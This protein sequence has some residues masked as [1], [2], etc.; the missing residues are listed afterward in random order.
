MTLRITCCHT[1]GQ[2]C[3][4]TREALCRH[5]LPGTHVLFTEIPAGDPHAYGHALAA[6]WKLALERGHALAVVEPDIVVR[7]D[8]IVSFLTHEAGYVAYPYP[9]TTDVGP[10]LGCNR[11]S[12][13]FIA[14]Y[15]TAMREAVD[16]GVGWEQLDVVFVRHVL[17]RKYGEQPTVL[18]PPVVHLNEAKEL[19]PGASSVPLMS[20]P[21]W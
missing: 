6:Q 1:P 17:A 20:V 9:W 13:A 7:R 15:P 3:D 10:A 12:A 21:H 14:R 4:E 11:F 5:Q 16:S 2:L 18:L 8:V 19:L